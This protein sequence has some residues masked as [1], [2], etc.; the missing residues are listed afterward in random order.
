MHIRADLAEAQ[1]TAWEQVGAPGTWW[2]S[3]ERIAIAAE[4][5]HALACPLCIARKDAVSPTMVGGDHATLGA[6]SRAAVEAVHR[7][8][9]DPGRIGEAWHRR[10]LAQG[11]DADRYAE[12]VSIVAITVAIDTFRHALGLDLWPP[13]PA[14]PGTP[15]GHRPRGVQPGPGWGFFLPAESRDADDPDLYREHPGPRQRSPANIILALSAVPY[16]MMHWWDLMEA[17]YQPGPW[18]RDYGR[19]YRAISHAQIEM[20]A[21]RVAALNRCEY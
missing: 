12:L 18:M 15:R 17:M 5:R 9:T 21:A 4:T 1:R 6:L 7:I 14:Q 16:S 2:T 8:R 11:L 20:L 19:E 13:P 3:A 10:V